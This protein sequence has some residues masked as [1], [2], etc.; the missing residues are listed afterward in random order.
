LEDA[1]TSFAAVSELANIIRNQTNSIRERSERPRGDEGGADEDARARR[2]A[3]I[4]NLADQVVQDAIGFTQDD[5]TDGRGRRRRS[6]LA[7]PENAEE[8]E[9]DEDEVCMSELTQDI[10]I[11][12]KSQLEKR[13]AENWPEIK[14]RREEDVARRREAA[15]RRNNPDPNGS[16]RD[17]SEAVND[18][19][20]LKQ[21]QVNGRIVIADESR[22][23]AFGHGLEQAAMEGAAVAIEDDRIYRVVHQG[24]LGK[25]AGKMRQ[26]KWGEE[27]LDLFYK[28]LRMFGTDFSMIANLFPSHIDRRAVKKKYL[29]ELEKNQQKCDEAVGAK[30]AFSIEDYE[31][32]TSMEFE[33]PD[34]LMKELEETERRLRE[35]DEQRRRDAGFVDN[36]HL[37]QAQQQQH[38][39]ADVPLPTTERDDADEE[40]PEGADEAIEGEAEGASLGATRRTQA[41]STAPSIRTQTQAMADR[42]VQAAVAGPKKKQPRKARESTGTGR[43]GRGG[44][45]SR[46]AV[47]GVEEVVGPVGEVQL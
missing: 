18:G 28:G 33:D 2:T 36:H 14:K 47:E 24:T 43:G 34:K 3:H 40:Q 42:V 13:M 41:P 9:I 37:Q 5:E 11:G 1:T 21:I 39:G 17:P 7:T 45:K 31:N 23:V 12:K 16:Q 46:K 32:L 38:D 22:E 35:E 6:R 8:L 29:I 25:A 15:L 27:E 10:K 20:E 30:E 44:R 19:F 4:Q 26:R